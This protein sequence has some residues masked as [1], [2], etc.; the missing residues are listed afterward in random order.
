M[1]QFELIS[2]AASEITI[3]GQKVPINHDKNQY[4]SL[5]IA[6]LLVFP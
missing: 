6:P 4:A 2:P 3:H 5:K 1:E